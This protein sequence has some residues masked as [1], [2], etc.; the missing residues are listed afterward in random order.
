MASCCFCYLWKNFGDVTI[1]VDGESIRTVGSKSE[2]INFNLD[3]DY[4]FR[5][6]NAKNGNNELFLK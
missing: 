6:G 2:P 4:D 3:T 1:Y 5:I